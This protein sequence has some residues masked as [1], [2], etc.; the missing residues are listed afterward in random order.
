[1]PL[2]PRRLVIAG[3]VLSLAL[4]AAACG[5][6]SGSTGTAQGGSSS[7]ASGGGGGGGTC[8]IALLLPETK[9]TRYETQDRPDFTN[10]VRQLDS[11][12]NIDYYNAQQDQN[13]QQSQAQTALSKG[14]NVL[15]LDAVNGDAAA[16]I[17]N[18]AKRQNVPVIAYDRLSS[19]AVTYYVSFDNKRVGQL[20]AQTLVSAMK[21]NGAKAGADIVMINGSPDDPNAADFKA[22]AHSVLDKSGFKIAAEYD[23]QGWDPTTAGQE[24]ATAISKIGAAAIKGVYVANDGMAA[25]AIAAMQHANMNPLPP[26][27]GQDAQLDAIQ[28]ILAGQQLMT[29]YKAIEPEA[30]DAAQA[31]VNLAKG[32]KPNA[33]TTVTNKTSDK[34]PATLLTPVAVTASNVKDTVVKDGFWK[35]SQICTAQYKK[36]C[37]KYGIGS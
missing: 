23:T 11:S 22:G 36:Y 3:T 7:Q 31:A 5:G 29:V 14:D 18:V 15:V 12:C 4:G 20:Q 30:S 8:K 19:G 9:T 24:M 26:T 35:P 10:K 13:Q 21:K 28:R 1:M 16:G 34:V 2:A 17:V 6:S 37:Q 27:T 33:K 32:Q 25:G